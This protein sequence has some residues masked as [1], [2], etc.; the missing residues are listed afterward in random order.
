MNPHLISFTALVGQY[1][2]LLYRFS[3]FIIRNEAAASIIASNALANLW[4]NRHGVHT[5]AEARIILKTTTRVLCHTWLREQALT[6]GKE[7]NPQEN[8]GNDQP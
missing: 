2:T 5:A 6:L 3:R 1:H 4:E 8:E 7:D